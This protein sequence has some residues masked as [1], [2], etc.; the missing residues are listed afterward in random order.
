MT[1][2]RKTTLAGELVEN[3]SALL[4][5]TT[6]TQTCTSPRVCAIVYPYLAIIV[7]RLNG[8]TTGKRVI[9]IELAP[10]SMKKQ[11]RR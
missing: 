9:E 6:L 4:D 2:Y 5:G 11:E 10:R 8:E 7:A 1:L 3:V